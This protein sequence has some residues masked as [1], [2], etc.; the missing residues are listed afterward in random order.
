MDRGMCLSLKNKKVL[1]KSNDTFH[2]L[3]DGIKE[4]DSDH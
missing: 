1:A 3:M 2:S 4:H